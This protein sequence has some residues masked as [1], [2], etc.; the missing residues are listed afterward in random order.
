M[1]QEPFLDP[2]ARLFTELHVID[3]SVKRELAIRF[4]IEKMINFAI[5]HEVDPPEEETEH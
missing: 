4:C 2:L 3:N 5:A 1:R